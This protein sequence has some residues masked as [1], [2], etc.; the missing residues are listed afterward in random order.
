MEKE[1]GSFNEHTKNIF[2]FAFF[3]PLANGQIFPS[4]GSYALLAFLPGIPTFRR[5][6]AEAWVPH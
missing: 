2:I 4:H 6:K 1:R 3:Y 5:P